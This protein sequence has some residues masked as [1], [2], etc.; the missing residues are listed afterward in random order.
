MARL[1]YADL[2]GP[3]AG[4]LVERFVAGRGSVL[5]LY[6]MLAHSPLVA[7][8][9]LEYLTAIRQQTLL[10]PRIRE[11]VILRIAIL[12]RAA[13]ETDQ[14]APIARKAGVTPEQI[15][16]L[17]DW[18]SATLFDEETRAVLAFTDAMT[19]DVVVPSEV[20]SAVASQYDERTIVELTATIAAYNMVSRFLVALEIRS[21]DSVPPQ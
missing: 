17:D 10:S 11:L 13:Y 2:R 1:S 6:Q 12:N 3:A 7:S 15:E 19:Q 9:W 16:A 4:P 5:H 14:H 20:F 21:E 18:R 8:G